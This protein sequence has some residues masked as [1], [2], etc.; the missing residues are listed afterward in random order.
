MSLHIKIIK[1]NLSY[2]LHIYI[3]NIINKNV[4]CIETTPLRITSIRVFI[5]YTLAWLGL[6]YFLCVALD[7]G[8]RIYYTISILEVFEKAYLL[9]SRHIFTLDNIDRRNR[10]RH[11]TMHRLADTQK[12]LL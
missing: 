4:F 1:E 11:G 5:K 8:M 6:F 2:I 12:L 10:A 9:T 3:L 7:S